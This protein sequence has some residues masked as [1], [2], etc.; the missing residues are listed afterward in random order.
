MAELYAARVE[1][2][3]ACLPELPVSY[4]DFSTWHRQWLQG[5]EYAKQ[6]AFWRERLG[7]AGQAVQ[8]MNI[9]L[10]LDEKTSL[11]DPGGYP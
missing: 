11:E 8:S 2:R 3:D 9:T 5:P 7:G 1:G 10:G 6:L 4:L